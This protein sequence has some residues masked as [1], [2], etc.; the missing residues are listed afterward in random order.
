[1]D[2]GLRGGEREAGSGGAAALLAH[3]RGLERAGRVAEALAALAPAR[4]DPGVR[5]AVVRLAGHVAPRPPAA[6]PVV[7]W[8][9]PVVPAQDGPESAAPVYLRAVHPLGVVL[10]GRYAGP[11]GHVVDPLDGVVRG[12]VPERPAG[13][14]G[15]VV[16]GSDWEGGLVGRDL[17]TRRA[18]FHLRPEGEPGWLS[19]RVAG[20]WLVVTEGG[21]GE[22]RLAGFDLADPRAPVRRWV[23]PLSADRHALAAGGE[24]ALV[25]FVAR[26]ELV[27]FDLETGAE[28]WRRRPTFGEPLA[29]AAGAVVDLGASVVALDPGGA[30]RWGWRSLLGHPTLLWGDRVVADAPAPD[31][32]DDRVHGAPARLAL[33]DRATGREVPTQETIPSGPAAA[34]GGLLVVYDGPHVFDPDCRDDTSIAGRSLLALGPDGSIRW[35]VPAEDVVDSAVTS[36]AALGERLYASTESGRVVCLEA[37]G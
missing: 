2:D 7:R 15:D 29:D 35:R 6:A 20:R 24:M 8:S 37:P 4:G 14:V 25:R 3:A 1:V 18:V 34:A 5:A 13:A 28:R 33:L 19:P 36:L 21:A 30:E 27:A 9:V 11:A 10:G 23:T 31:L 26:R 16:V 12:P 17:W 32:V 22:L